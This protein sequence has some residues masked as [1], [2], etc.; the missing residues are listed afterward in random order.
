M[1]APEAKPLGYV[2]DAFEVRTMHGK[3]R[4]SARRGREGEKSDFFSILLEIQIEELIVFG[5]EVQAGPITGETRNDAAMFPAES[6]R[7]KR[8][9]K[10]L[11]SH[12]C[13]G[14]QTRALRR[15]QR[16]N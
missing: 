9:T 14:G 10:V 16:V 11:P 5:R 15:R 7:F 12:G 1:K 3:R 13:V 6:G 4:V 8:L 2:E